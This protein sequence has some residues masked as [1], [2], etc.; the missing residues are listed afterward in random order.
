MILLISQHLHSPEKSQSLD[1]WSTDEANEWASIHNALP[2][3]ISSMI[4]HR[5]PDYLLTRNCFW[6][7]WTWKATNRWRSTTTAQESNW[8]LDWF[9]ETHSGSP[10]L[11]IVIQVIDLGA[12]V[13]RERVLRRLAP[14]FHSDPEWKS[15]LNR[16]RHDTLTPSRTKIKTKS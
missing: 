7:S 8:F 3:V 10:I 15:D 2:K 11:S 13:P 4:S 1:H 5:F 16:P 6:L 14:R 12:V 9:F